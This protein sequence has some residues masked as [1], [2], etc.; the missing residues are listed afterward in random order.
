MSP[1]TAKYAAGVKSYGTR[2]TRVRS[3]EGAGMGRSRA[4]AADAKVLG[5][6]SSARA[7]RL[8]PSR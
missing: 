2:G 1:K 6:A 3:A 5:R 4:A 7:A 8:R